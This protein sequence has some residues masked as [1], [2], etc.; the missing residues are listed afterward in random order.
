MKKFYVYILTNWNNRVLYVGVTN[1][2]QRRVYE[3]R[4][5]EVDGFTKKY[6]VYKL[7]HL[8][9]YGQVEEAILREK[10]VKGYRREKKIKLVTR[11]NPEW[12]DLLEMG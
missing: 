6:N 9:E 11:D 10:Q 4:R 8:E 7:V 5:G 3:H 12:V 1:D 2:I